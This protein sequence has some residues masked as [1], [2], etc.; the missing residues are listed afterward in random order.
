MGS[1]GT[2]SN[3]QFGDNKEICIEPS[4]TQPHSPP[5]Q[6]NDVPQSDKQFSR[7]DENPIIQVIPPS[8]PI[9]Q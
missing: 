9:Q 5:A 6:D 8:L 1:L 4:T 7:D 3:T 2:N